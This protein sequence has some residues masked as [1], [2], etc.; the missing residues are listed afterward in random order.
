MATCAFIGHRKIEK[1]ET[2][3]R[4]LAQTVNSLINEGVDTFLFGS[5]SAFDDLS[6]EIVTE[7][8]EIYTHIL[9]VFVRAEFEY[10]GQD[11]HDYLLTFYEETY[12]AEQAHNA[13]YRSYVKRNQAMIDKCDVLVTYC[14]STY[15]PTT[16][17]KSGTIMAMEYAQKKQKRIINLFE[18]L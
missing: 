8:K 18:L 16:R 14:D 9:R 5:R 15:T 6:Y 17:T 1:T 13:G 11:Y 7:L 4:R 10:I 3:I 12:F 2:L